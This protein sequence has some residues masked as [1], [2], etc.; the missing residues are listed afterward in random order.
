LIKLEG[1]SE[2]SLDGWG[3]MEAVPWGVTE[4]IG[5]VILAYVESMKS[6]GAEN[7]WTADHRSVGHERVAEY[8]NLLFKRQMNDGAWAPISQNDNPT[9]ARTYSTVIA[10]W[11]LLEIW[12]E[13]EIKA[14]MPAGKLRT[15]IKHAITWLLSTYMIDVASWVPN[16]R[17][18]GNIESFP[19]LTAQALFVLT[20]AR[21]DPEFQPIFKDN[22][23][24]RTAFSSFMQRLT[25]GPKALMDR[26]IS[27]NDRTHHSDRYL[28]NSPYMVE[29]STFLWYPW[30]LAVC[31]SVSQNPKMFGLNDVDGCYRLSAQSKLDEWVKFVEAQH[32]AYVK[33]ESLFAAKYF[34]ANWKHTRERVLVHFF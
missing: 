17:R 1:E 23:A 26:A 27:E 16:P 8:A 20:L 18:E 30:A 33:A 19:G 29:G 7:I 13:P 2:E 12:R 15:A 6:P 28:V 31:A 11:A 5:W 14:R 9:Y 3:Y 34:A 10:L 4:I 24:Y 21:Q 32:F 25:E 22:A